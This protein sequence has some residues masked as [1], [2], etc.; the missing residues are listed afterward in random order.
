MFQFLKPVY[1]PSERDSGTRLELL[2]KLGEK[3]LSTFEKCTY[4]FVLKAFQKLLENPSFF[5][6]AIR[7]VISISKIG[8]E[9][10][11]LSNMKNIGEKREQPADTRNSRFPVP[12]SS[13]INSLYVG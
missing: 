12:L 7:E 6:K 5:S 4:L 1:E 11:S 2:E 9:N 13:F 10:S 8:R 3:A